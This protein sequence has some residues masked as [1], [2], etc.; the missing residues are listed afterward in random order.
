MIYTFRHL[1]PWSST[2][3]LKNIFGYF[4]PILIIKFFSHL[5]STHNDCFAGSIMSMYW[6]IGIIH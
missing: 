2:T 4:T 3:G 1:Y 5:S 6:Y